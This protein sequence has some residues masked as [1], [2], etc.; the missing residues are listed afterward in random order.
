MIEVG[1][2]L[3]YAIKMP[4]IRCALRWPLIQSGRSWSSCFWVSSSKRP[5]H[6][7]KC[8]RGRWY[9]SVKESAIWWG[10]KQRMITHISPRVVFFLEVECFGVIGTLRVLT[11]WTCSSRVLIQQ[12]SGLGRQKVGHVL[13]TSLT[14]RCTEFHEFRCFTFDLDIPDHLTEKPTNQVIERIQVINPVSPK[15]LHWGIG[16]YHATK[17]DQTGTDQNRIH[18]GCKILVGSICRD[19]LTNGCV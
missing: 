16:Y 11:E 15:G 14:R 7:L 13:A 18:N 9:P 19:S 4:E 8:R 17:A 1:K 12:I 3:Q 6:M 5:R 10:P 2:Q